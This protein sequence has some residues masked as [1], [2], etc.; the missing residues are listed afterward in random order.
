MVFEN[1]SDTEP[2]VPVTDGEWNAFRYVAGEMS[3][4]ESQGFEA[5]LDQ[6]QSAR[7]AVADAVALVETLAHTDAVRTPAI[8][9]GS[10]KRRSWAGWVGAAAA[11]VLLV[12]AFVTLR[13]ASTPT[14]VAEAPA[15][16]AADES[17]AGVALAWSEVRESYPQEQKSWPDFLESESTDAGLAPATAGEPTAELPADPT[18]DFTLPAW[19]LSATALASGDAGNSSPVEDSQ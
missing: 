12:A 4:E 8:E 5:R 3:D 6:D 13:S 19:L 7:E 10:S 16:P 18:A 2:T 11:C 15:S 17:L 1:A 14:T 9:R